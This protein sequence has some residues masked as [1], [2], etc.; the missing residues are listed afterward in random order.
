MGAALASATVN[1]AYEYSRSGHNVVAGGYL[2]L[3]SLFGMVMFREFLDQF[4][5]GA[6]YVKRENPKF[7][8]RWITWP[9]NTFCAAVAWRNHPPAEGT[10]ATVLAAIA[11][12]DRVRALKAA[13]READVEARHEQNFPDPQAGRANGR[14]E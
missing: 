8:M 7:G 3:L 10:Q 13:A 1:F 14:V 11:N 6:A 9:T 5:E 2:G 12:L 4:E